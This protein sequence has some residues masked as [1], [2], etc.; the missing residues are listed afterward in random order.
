MVFNASV[1]RV[2]IATPSDLT[3]ERDVIERCILQWTT[4]NAHHDGIVLLPIRWE[5]SYSPTMSAAPQDALNAQFAHH[6]DMVIG[7]FWTRMGT[8]TRDYEG[9]AEEEID[10]YISNNKPTMI[11]FSDKLVAPSQL[12]HEQHEK[13]EAYKKKAL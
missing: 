7:S 10:W 11:Y 12:V 3:E 5:N 4:K 13:L 2:L 1:F 9:G 6:C 8:P